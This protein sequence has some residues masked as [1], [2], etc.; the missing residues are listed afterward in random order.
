MTLKR[1]KIDVTFELGADTFD[2]D[3]NDQ[4][5]VSGLRVR[6]E[7]NKPGG[8]DYGKMDCTIYGLTPSVVNKLTL[9]GTNFTDQRAQN[10]SPSTNNFITLK[11]GDE[12]GSMSVAYYGLIQQ[13]WGDFNSM[14]ETCLTISATQSVPQS[15]GAATPTSFNGPTDAATALG[16]IAFA[17]GITLINEN[18]NVILSSPYYPGSLISQAQSIAQQADI[19]LLFDQVGGKWAMIIWPNGLSRQTVGA[20]PEVSSATGMIGAPIFS[21]TGIMV[22]T[23]YNPAIVFGAS[24]NVV[25]SAIKRANGRWRVDALSHSLESETPNGNWFTSLQCGIPYNSVGGSANT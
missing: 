22:K 20:L 13:A 12:G 15:V 19:N 7:I 21:Q 9:I 3:N 6:A 16:K 14:P 23:I 4:V 18:V 17:L 2:D 10:Y 8:V 1:R 24:V 5:T 25:S 11:A